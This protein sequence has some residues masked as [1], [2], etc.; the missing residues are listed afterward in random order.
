MPCICC[1]LLGMAAGQ[2]VPEEH[3]VTRLGVIWANYDMRW[4]AERRE[5]P[6]LWAGHELSQH[7][8]APFQPTQTEKRGNF[9]YSREMR[10]RWVE[11]ATPGNFFELG[12][13]KNWFWSGGF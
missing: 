10:K 11:R 1:I 2:C 9:E 8:G 13:G 3:F 12:L 5:H 4:W 6:E 7:A